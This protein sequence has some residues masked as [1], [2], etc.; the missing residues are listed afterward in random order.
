M[1]YRHL[2]FDLDHTLWDFK[3]NSRE[4]LGEL[5]NAH[6]AVYGHITPDRF[7]SVYEQV[8]ERLWAR[9]DLGEIPKEVLRALRFRE[10]LAQFGVQDTAKAALLDRLYMDQC[11]RRGRLVRGAME[12]LGA[13]HGQFNLH[14]ITNGFTETQ[15]LKLHSCGLRHFFKVVLTSEMA[16]VAK[17]SAR[18]FR[19]ALRSA[20]AK[21]GES[22]MIGDSIHADMAGARAAGIDQVHFS[23]PGT[24]D[25]LATYAISDLAALRNIL[26]QGEVA[27]GVNT[28]RSH[29]PARPAC[30]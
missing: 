24:Q 13:L 7:I 25:P 15:E 12:L 21:A 11:P 17:P 16:G 20:G 30:G 18:I 1:K 28:A 29:R 2:F 8:N 9:L 6:L 4:V 22:L 27:P 5:C 10:T 26:A 19:H 14:V 23:G 3:A